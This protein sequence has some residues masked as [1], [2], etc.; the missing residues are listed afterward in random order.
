MFQPTDLSPWSYFSLLLIFA[1]ALFGGHT[2]RCSG[3]TSSSVLGSAQETI[4]YPGPLHA[5]PALR[6][7][8]CLSS[9]VK[10]WFG[11]ES[12]CL[13]FPSQYTVHQ[14]SFIEKTFLS[15]LNC[16]YSFVTGVDK[17]RCVLLLLWGHPQWCLEATPSSVLGTVRCWGWNPGFLH[18]KHVL[19]RYLLSQTLGLLADSSAPFISLSTRWK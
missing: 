7:S 18:S 9:A 8:S 2:W 14:A 10:I 19:S 15:T 12:R 4:K 1:F 13:F 6:P 5:K 11:E 17:Y 16:F 3:A